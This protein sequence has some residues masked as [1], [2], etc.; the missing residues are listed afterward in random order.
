MCPNAAVVNPRGNT[1]P[2]ATSRPIHIHRDAG[3]QD[4]LQLNS[5]HE[6]YNRNIN[7]F[8]A[9]TAKA[10]TTGEIFFHGIGLIFHSYLR[11]VLGFLSILLITSHRA[12]R[13]SA[14]GGTKY[15]KIPC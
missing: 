6:S 15:A 10:I 5:K 4:L 2:A 11:L 8:T 3:C 9:R 1:A 13:K 12:M 7:P 14:T